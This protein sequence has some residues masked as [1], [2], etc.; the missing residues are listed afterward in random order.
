[1][2]D[3]VG[4]FLI[5]WIILESFFSLFSSEGRRRE[6]ISISIRNQFKTVRGGLGQPRPEREEGAN[7]SFGSSTFAKVV[8]SNKQA[9]KEHSMNASC[10]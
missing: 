4:P 5:H 3:H 8:Y 7:M 10:M 2:S 9:T 1:M 6:Y